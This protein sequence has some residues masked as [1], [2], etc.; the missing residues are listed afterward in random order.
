MRTLLLVSLLA[1]CTPI[2]VTPG[3]RTFTTDSPAAPAGGTD[4]QIAA[5]HTG[6]I[7][8]PSVGTGGVRLRHTIEPGVIGEVDGGTLRVDNDGDGP[9]RN[10]YTGRLGVLLQTAGQHAAFGV[11]VGGGIAPAAGN[12]TSVDAGVV[13][14][15]GYRYLRPV[16]GGWVGYS[17]PAGNRTFTV[18]AGDDRTTLRLPHDLFA[19]VNLGLEIGPPD[20]ALLVGMTV[21]QF[22]LREDSV[23]AHETART[24]GTADPATPQLDQSFVGGMLGFRLAL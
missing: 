2:A 20:C 23:V 8:G 14:G 18:T 22:W 15:G 16:L 5:G 9:N 3:A 21:V 24:A 10:A 1:A 11:G 7:F 4:V 17:A 6:Q 12:W 13:V 19:T